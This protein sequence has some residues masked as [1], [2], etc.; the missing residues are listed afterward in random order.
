MKNK[1]R[2]IRGSKMGINLPKWEEL[3]RDEQVPIVNLPL[4]GNYVVV[5]GPGT[6]KTI[7]ALYRAARWRK[8]SENADSEISFLIF[9]RTLKQY[10]QD[11]IDKMEL[12]DSQVRTWHSWIY[13]FY[14]DHARGSCP[15]ISKYSPDWDKIEKDLEEVLKHKHIEYLIL[16]EAQDFPPK[17]LSILARVSKSAT[18]FGDSQQALTNALSTTDDFTSAFNAGRKVHYLNQNYRNTKEISDLAHLFYTGDETDIPARPR[19][20]GQKPRLTKCKDFEEA[21]SIIANYSNNNPALNIGVLIP[22]CSDRTSRI[23][24][25]CSSISTKSKGK[26]QK[27]ISGQKI[28]PESFSFDD[29]GVKILSY[30]TMKG[31][32]FDAVFMVDIDDAFFIEE[33]D[34]K[35]KAVYVGSTRAKDSLTFLYINDNKSFILEKLK[36]NVE[37]LEISVS[38]ST[39][40]AA[41]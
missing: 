27:Y 11:S 30:N 12:E 37:L 16:D 6:G 25:Y 39:G 24:R 8:I 10:I 20:T 18:I 3:S 4:N 1:E 14:K 35:N 26:V 15:E 19:R 29:D 32:E 40:K 33:N 36:D 22:N 2:E 7:L 17:L 23:I 34:L 28:G 5:G 41:F 31:L 9:N 38:H 13:N 21:T